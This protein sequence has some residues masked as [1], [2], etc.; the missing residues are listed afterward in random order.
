MYL[1]VGGVVCIGAVALDGGAGAYETA[2]TAGRESVGGRA[3]AAVLALVVHAGEMRR[4]HG[5]AAGTQ[6]AIRGG[7][8]HGGACA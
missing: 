5:D 3:L 8:R 6:W 2:H 4:G 7:G 1:D